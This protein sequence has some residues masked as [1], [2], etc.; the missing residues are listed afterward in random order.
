VHGKRVETNLI[1]ENLASKVINIFEMKNPFI[2]I[3]FQSLIQSVAIATR[4]SKALTD[5]VLRYFVE[6]AHFYVLVKA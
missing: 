6:V 2:L 3:Y 1:T 5:H 4:S